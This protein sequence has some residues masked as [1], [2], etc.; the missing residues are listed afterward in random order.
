MLS[1]VCLLFPLR[2]WS[3]HCFFLSF[4]RRKCLQPCQPLGGKSAT[5]G[6][7]VMR[8][9]SWTKV[10]QLYGHL[11]SKNVGTEL[12]PQGHW[13]GKWSLEER[14]MAGHQGH[15][16]C[17]V[18]WAL[19]ALFLHLFL[20]ILPSPSKIP[21]LEQ[22]SPPTVP[23]P[24]PLKGSSLSPH[25]PLSATSFSYFSWSLNESIQILPSSFLSCWSLHQCGF[26]WAGVHKG[27]LHG[28]GR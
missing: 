15:S 5:K 8:A 6:A 27:L 10:M 3:L 17:T 7:G 22:A 28:G 24:S 1:R 14:A 13:A 2:A 23:K 19:R 20:S 26:Q 25:L 4:L 16:L 12:S 21:D 9:F 11:C 18:P